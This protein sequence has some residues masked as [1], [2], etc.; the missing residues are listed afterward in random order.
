MQNSYSNVTLADLCLENL[1]TD[2]S[3][4]SLDTA[5][6]MMEVS[7]EDFLSQDNFF[8]NLI[9]VKQ[10]SVLGRPRSE[11]TSSSNTATSSTPLS[12]QS[13]RAR[14]TSSGST[15]ST[16]LSALWGTTSNGI[17][18]PLSLSMMGNLYNDALFSPNAGMLVGGSLGNG[19]DVFSSNT[20]GKTR[21]CSLD[22]NASDS[23]VGE[24]D[25]EEN[26]PIAATVG[27]KVGGDS[28]IN[29]ST[30]IEMMLLADD[31]VPLAAT[32][33][34]SRSWKCFIPNCDKF[35]YT[36]SG[37]RYHMRNHHQLKVPIRAIKQPKKMRQT[38][39]TCETCFKTYTTCAGLKYHK[40]TGQCML[41]GG[42]KEL[43]KIP[44]Q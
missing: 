28:T 20:C 24:I 38:V 17:M 29:Y 3:T 13:F 44:E 2:P 27:S 14:S 21:R 31:N 25:F 33:S 39:W 34:K 18:T 23:T 11:T 10:E 16:P 15:I 42:T 32:S 26:G 22:S 1:S 19:R 5:N 35:Y 6:P 30:D 8:S 9:I 41:Q 4:E 12:A 43:E 36:G 37:L 40:K 7:V